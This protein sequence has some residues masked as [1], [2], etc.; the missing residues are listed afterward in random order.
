M[1]LFKKSKKYYFLAGLPRAGNT[2]LSSLLN[3]NPRVQ[4]SANSIVA[5]IFYYILSQEDTL[6][7][8]NF[9]DLQ[10]IRDCASAVFDSYYKSWEGNI[11]IDRAPWG[12]QGNLR[13]LEDYCPN[14][15]KFIC[16]IRDVNQVLASF[17]LNYYK[18]GALNKQNEKE[19]EDHCH[20]MMGSSSIQEGVVARALEGISNFVKPE[21]SDR[22]YFMHYDNFCENAE[23]ELNNIYDFLEIKR[24]KHNFNTI[25]QYEMNGIKYNDNIDIGYY[26]L[27]TIKE[28]I[29]KSHYRVEDVLPP[30]IIKEYSHLTFNQF[31]K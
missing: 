11:I 25:K 4:V 26:N 28:S 2:V 19:V 13:I 5:S 15:L 9:P 10:S 3:Q 30:S 24:Y 8:K 17:V 18:S 12:T 16:P 27:H 23:E 1:K 7:Y 22:V 20:R 21:Y 31:R 14:E 29:Q 6:F